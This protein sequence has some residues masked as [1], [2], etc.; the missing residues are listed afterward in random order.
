MTGRAGK[1]RNVIL[2]WLVWPLIT[3][4]IYH[5]VWWFKINR[6]AG[7]FDERIEVSPVLSL[8]AILVGWI[9]IVPP[10]WS[11]YQTGERIGQMQAD[12]GMERSCN[13]LIGLLLSFVL[14]LHSL[15]Y[16]AELNRIW[17]R[18][19]YPAEGTLVSVSPGPAGPG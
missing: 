2:V 11:I 6:E 5:F 10:F 8:L 16:Q 9:I 14:S 17:E 18:L 15:Y 7:D 13:G 19:G 4:G 1:T 3:L 12:A